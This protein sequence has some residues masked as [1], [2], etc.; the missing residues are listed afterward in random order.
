[1]KLTCSHA[2]HGFQPLLEKLP[3]ANRVTVLTYS[4]DRD[5]QSPLFAGLRN[6]PQTCRLTLITNIPGRWPS[7]SE[8]QEANMRAKFDAYLD[9]LTPDNFPCASDVYFSFS[10]H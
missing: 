9:N 5:P 4:L 3:S 2:A 10:N 1:M 8:Q 7:Y 6:L